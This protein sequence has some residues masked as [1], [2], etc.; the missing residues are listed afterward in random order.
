MRNGRLFLLEDCYEG[1]D[2]FPQLVVRHEI[3]E[4]AGED[5]LL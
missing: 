5:L 3:I 1:V 2:W 4:Q